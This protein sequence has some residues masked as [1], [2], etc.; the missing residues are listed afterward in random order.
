MRTLRELIFGRWICCVIAAAL[1]TL[2]VHAEAKLLG[3]DQPIPRDVWLAYVLGDQKY[4]YEHLTVTKRDDGKYAYK[5]ESKLQLNFLGQQ[6]EITQSGTYIVT[7]NLEPVSVDLEGSQLSGKTHTSGHVEGNELVMTFLHDDLQR[8]QKINLADQ[9][10]FLVCL[11]DFLVCHMET[12]ANLQ[13]R[14]IDTTALDTELAKCELIEKSDTGSKWNLNLG[15]ENYGQ[16]TI[17]LDATGVRSSADFR[18]PK[19]S[20]RRSNAEV[21]KQ[22]EHLNFA[23]RDLLI[24][25]LGRDI[26]PIQQVTSLSIRLDWRGD[27]FELLK[28]EDERQ[29]I[30][31]VKRDGDLTTVVLRVQTAEDPRSE[32]PFPLNS[33][34]WQLFL[35]EDRFIKPRDLSVIQQTKTW[36]GN[37]KTALGAVKAIS[38]GI[39]KYMQGG[40]MIAETLNAPEILQCKRGK[41]AEFSILFASAARSLGIPTRVVLG[42][43]IINGVWVGHLWNESYIGRWITVDST[44]NEVGGSTALLKLVESDSVHGT[45]AIRWKATDAI[46]VVCLDSVPPISS[47]SDQIPA[48]IAGS[49]YTNPKFACRL[50][51]PQANW[52]LKDVSK[53]GL[54][55]SQTIIRFQV[56]DDDAILI[57]FVPLDLPKI[58][59]PEMLIAARINSFK[60]M[61][62]NF[63]ILK[64]EDYALNSMKG[65]LFVFERTQGSDDDVRMKT[66][67]LI[68]SNQHFTY[69]T[70]LIANEEAHDEVAADF[71]KLLQ[72]FEN[73]KPNTSAK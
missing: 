67:E 31:D 56:P 17:T 50:V 12:A 59:T 51:A 55:S 63:K 73:L 32:L 20:L 7:A 54:L 15:S 60:L 24:F 43:R 4:G 58:Y 64:N 29:K 61:Y 71:F 25:P 1:A 26:G 65:R 28:L 13:P 38:A 46:D 45:Q 8:Q 5:I 69:L 35:A 52:V 72:S 40:S 70:N 6:Q 21:S 44:V 37:E 10:I 30:V 2:N 18:V 11:D 66:T 62:K 41:C 14:I 47:D 27:G 22:I 9:P 3:A 57:H 36:I 39:F 53:K 23:N 33:D 34:A 19:L 49:I 42:M 48:E 68:W 16:A